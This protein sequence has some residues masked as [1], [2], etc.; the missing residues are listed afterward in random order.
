[1][2]KTGPIVIIEDDLDDQEMLTI[3]FKELDVKNEMRFFADGEGA[4]EYLRLD[5]VFPFLILSDLNL[6]KID[7]F[8]LKK[9]IQQDEKVHAKS[10]PYLFFSTHIDVNFIKEAYRISIQGIFKKPDSYARL[11]Y[12]IETIVDYWLLSY[13]PGPSLIERLE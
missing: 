6:P 3:I 12:T 9:I 7:G 1:M 4:L 5:T 11:K 10:I 13:T 8:N 2:N